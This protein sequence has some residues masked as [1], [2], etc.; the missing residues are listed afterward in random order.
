MSQVARMDSQ[1]VCR[2][3]GDD[4]N[5]LQSCNVWASSIMDVLE[6]ILMF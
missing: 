3:E 2:N 4:D 1:L 5:L 6:R